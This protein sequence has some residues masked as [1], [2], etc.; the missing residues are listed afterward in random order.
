M[1]NHPGQLAEASS[2]PGCAEI[3]AEVTSKCE[4][5]GPKH[6]GCVLTPLGM[7]K[8]LLWKMG[9]Q[10]RS[11]GH[12]SPPPPL[13]CGLHSKEI[14]RLINFTDI[15][16]DQDPFESETQQYHGQD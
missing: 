10:L 4:E 16:I 12:E 5:L 7:N 14:F 15:G 2:V 13:V 9:L 6:L 11:V 8:C 1:D 3:S